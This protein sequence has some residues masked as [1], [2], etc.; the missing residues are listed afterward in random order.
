MTG[1]P[2]LHD[3]IGY[4]AAFLTTVSFLPQAVLTIRTRDTSSLSLS[5]YS[6]F[7]FGVLLW[8]VYGIFL[9]N[10]AIVA[11]NAVTLMLSASIL[12][13]KIYNTLTGQEK[14]E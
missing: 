8:L 9:Q 10:I 4:I 5:M 3:L 1:V 12:Y 13:M 2:S 11:A 6:L 14:S 7:T